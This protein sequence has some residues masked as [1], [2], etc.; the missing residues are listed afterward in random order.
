MTLFFFSDAPEF[1]NSPLTQF[2]LIEGQSA[3]INLSARGNPSQI[4]YKWSRDKDAVM[5]K[6]RFTS[7]GPLLNISSISRSDVGIYK[8]YATNDLGTSETAIRVNVNCE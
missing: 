4:Q 3:A 7:D 8:L 1:I 2:D 5:D 6:N